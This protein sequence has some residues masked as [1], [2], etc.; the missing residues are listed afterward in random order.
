MITELQ[1]IPHTSYEFN[2]LINCNRYRDFV[3]QTGRMISREDD[4]QLHYWFYINK[5]RYMNY[6]DNRCKY[7][8]D[9]L[10]FLSETKTVEIDG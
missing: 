4:Q 10:Y 2:F 3:T 6:N 9:L 1:D 7:F 8:K 5:G